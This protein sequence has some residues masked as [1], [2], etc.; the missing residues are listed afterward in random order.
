MIVEQI[1][2]EFQQ[3]L[4]VLKTIQDNGFEAYFVGGSVRDTILGLPIHDVDI[5]TSAYPAEVKALFKKTVDTGI[6]HGTVMVI[7]HGEGYEV[8]T[9]RTESGYQD[10]RRPDKVTFVRSLAD[11]LKRRDLTINALAMDM[12]GEIVDLFG[13]LD[14]LKNHLIRAVGVPAE[15]YHEDALR[16]MRTVRFASKL[17]FAIDPTT[18]KA[19]AENAPLLAKIAV[20]RIH[21]EW[22]KLLQGRN[23][24]RGVQ[25]FIDT[26][27]YQYCPGLKDYRAELAQLLTLPAIK[28]TSEEAVWTL[29]TTLCELDDSQVSRL[30]R[31]WKSSREII[32][33]TLKARVALRALRQ[34][35]LDA[36]ML[37]QTG[38]P[39]LLVANQVAAFFKNQVDETALRT[40]YE[41]LPI[42]SKR[43]LVLTGNDLLKA[44]IITPGPRMGQ[45]L[46]T[47]EVE[48]VQGKVANQTA[49]LMGRACELAK[50]SD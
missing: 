3:A 12:N 30:L 16:M 7:D 35:Q 40:Q 46:N 11:D 47:L 50:Q 28:L 14:D 20:E 19:I 38:L 9:F 44:K 8:T 1:P 42:K 6:E 29:I 37:Y 22:V 33:N 10:Y 24:K 21:E 36:L 4:P 17:D 34:Q 23:I 32:H 5:A 48:V 18:E 15:R 2:S 49:A 27:L 26:G 25:A 39:L 41:K 45:I 31:Q 43:E 13:G